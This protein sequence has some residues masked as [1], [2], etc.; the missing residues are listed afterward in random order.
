MSEP[1][2]NVPLQDLVLLESSLGDDPWARPEE[3]V[4]AIHWSNRCRSIPGKVT[5][6]KWSISGRT[7]YRLRGPVN[8]GY[9]QSSPRYIVSQVYLLGEH[10]I[11]RWDFSISQDGQVV[12]EAWMN[13]ARQQIAERQ[14]RSEYAEDYLTVRFWVPPGRTIGNVIFHYQ[15]EQFIAWVA[16]ER[17]GTKNHENY[18]RWEKP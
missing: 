6:E 2:P 8:P 5:L 4:R 9:G 3:G 7:Y 15:E 11:E 12:H 14:Y 18:L 1:L 17:P 16:T 13:Q 10:G